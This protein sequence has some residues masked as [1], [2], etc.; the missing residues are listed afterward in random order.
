MAAL[1]STEPV[2]D[3]ETYDDTDFYE[4]LLRDLIESNSTA[5]RAPTP[6]DPLEYPSRVTPSSARRALLDDPRPP[7]GCT[8]ETGRG[9]GRVVL[10]VMPLRTLRTAEYH[11][12]GLVPTLHTHPTRLGRGRCRHDAAGPR[13]SQAA[14]P[15][16]QGPEPHIAY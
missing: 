7:V 6:V 8:G 15:P 10:P 9:T 14:N 2:L 11:R 13:A 4:L 1:Q 5:D 12:Y 16:P 3:E